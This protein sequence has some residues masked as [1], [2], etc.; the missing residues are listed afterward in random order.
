[1]A[2][3]AGDCQLHGMPD[4]EIAALWRAQRMGQQ[5]HAGV[6][7]RAVVVQAVE[8]GT[9]LGRDTVG[10]EEEGHMAAAGQAGFTR[11]DL[12]QQRRSALHV[13]G[14]ATVAGAQQGHIGVAEVVA[15][16][17]LRD[18]RHGLEGLER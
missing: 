14:F 6:F 8:A 13:H 12:G 5:Q 18:Q 10:A 4:V 11:A 17:R 2:H 15:P 16:G 7:A 9:R 3:A 1:M